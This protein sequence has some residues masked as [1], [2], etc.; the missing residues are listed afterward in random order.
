MNVCQQLPNDLASEMLQIAARSICDRPADNPAQRDFRT[1]QMVY[2]TMGMEPRDGLEY[3]LATMVVAHFNL[4]LDTMFDMFQG[5]MDLLKAKTK[6]TIVALDR[7]MLSFV[8]EMRTARRR[9]AARSAEDVARRAAEAT[10][11]TPEPRVAPGKTVTVPVPAPPAAPLVAPLAAALAAGPRAMDAA[12]TGRAAAPATQKPRQA[13]GSMA[14]PLATL[15]PAGQANGAAP[16]VTRI[17]ATETA[18]WPGET[19]TP[20]PMSGSPFGAAFGWKSVE[21]ET[22]EIDEAMLAEHIAAFQQAMTDAAAALAEARALDPVE[23]DA[24]VASGD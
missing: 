21:T 9:P 14:A 15:T 17:A 12:A 19:H 2:T 8:K 11:G 23:P 3:M 6:T 16:I 7:S 10:I 4:I 1:R 24:T 20:D 5:Q 13:N 18:A 22:R